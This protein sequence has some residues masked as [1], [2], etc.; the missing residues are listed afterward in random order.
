MPAGTDV[1]PLQ[2]RGDQVVGESVAEIAADA[3]E[4]DGVRTARAR[5]GFLVVRRPLNGA[6]TAELL[7]RLV[8]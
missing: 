1:A 4:R 3:G 5:L 2:R 7:N 8:G 6:P